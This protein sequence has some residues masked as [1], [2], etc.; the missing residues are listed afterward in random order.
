M[1][2]LQLC[3]LLEETAG[4]TAGRVEEGPPPGAE[5]KQDDHGQ[6]QHQGLQA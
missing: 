1:D 6:N 3:D 5:G 2:D 4:R